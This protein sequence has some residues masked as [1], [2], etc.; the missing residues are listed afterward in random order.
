MTSVTLSLG[1]SLSLTLRLSVTHHLSVTR[2]L[3]VTRHLSLARR[4]RVTRSRRAGNGS[5]AREITTPLLRIRNPQSAIRNLK[6][7]I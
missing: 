4:L 3:R 6:F 2:R 1:V 7:E 5:A